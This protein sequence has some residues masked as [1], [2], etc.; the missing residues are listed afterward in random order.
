[1]FLKGHQ[2]A[3]TWDQNTTA[4]PGFYILVM[5]RIGI[6]NPQPG[7][8]QYASVSRAERYVRRKEAVIN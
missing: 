7:S 6:A 1:M 2:E 4:K 5:S 3:T 8:A